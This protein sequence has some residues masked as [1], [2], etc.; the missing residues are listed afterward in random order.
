[1]QTIPKAVFLSKMY[2][3]DGIT[4]NRAT[5][6]IETYCSYTSGS[7]AGHRFTLMAW[8]KRMIQDMFGWKKADGSRKYRFVWL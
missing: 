3:F 8:Q 1:M 4:A 2:Y 5:S 6:F 7:L